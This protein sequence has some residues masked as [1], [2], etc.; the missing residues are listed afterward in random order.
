MKKHD[1]LLKTVMLIVALSVIV[2]AWFAFNNLDAKAT[3][4]ENLEEKLAR[5]EK[6][7]SFLQNENQEKDQEFQESENEKINES[8]NVF[9]ESVF[10]V[11]KDNWEERRSNAEQVLTK[12]I[13]KKTFPSDEKEGKVLYEYDVDDSRIYLRSNGEEGSA[14]VV[15]EQTV[16]NV[17]NNEKSK[18]LM[19]IEVF[20]KKEGEGWLINKFQQISST[21]I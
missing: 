3:K 13:F 10:N 21:P 16:K 8:I 6:Q 12:D 19:T 15:F 9:L 17:A 4:I 5:Q 2:G 18:N 20:L 1:F 14:Y 7:I 11:K